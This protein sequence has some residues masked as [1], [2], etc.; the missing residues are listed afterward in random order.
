MKRAK[1]VLFLFSAFIRLNTQRNRNRNK[2]LY[3]LGTAYLFALKLY[4]AIIINK[5]PSMSQGDILQYQIVKSI[6]NSKRWQNDFVTNELTKNNIP[7]GIRNFSPF[8]T[9]NRS[10]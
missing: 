9:S 3:T 4:S 1:N 2:N 5:N 10:K 7:I 6:G 8:L